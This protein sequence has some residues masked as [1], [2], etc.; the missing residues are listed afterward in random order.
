MRCP[1]DDALAAFV[2]GRLPGPRVRGVAEHVR[3]CDACCEVIEQYASA[4]ELDTP[5][6][7]AGLTDGLAPSQPTIAAGSSP[8]PGQMFARFVLLHLAGRGGMADVYAAYDPV[9]DRK[10]ALKLLHGDR[11]ARERLLHEAR[12]IAAID[13]PHVVRIF[14]L[15]RAHGRD[16]IAMEYVD[17]GTLAQWLASRPEPAAIVHAFV[18]AGRGLCAAHARGIVHRDFKPSNVLVTHVA[19]RLD[20][21][22]V[23]DFGLALPHGESGTRAGTRRYVAPEQATGAPPEPSA[24][25]YSLC[26]A[27]DEA[28]RGCL[29]EQ[30]PTTESV[31]PAASRVRPRVAAAIAR[32]MASDPA[33]R[34]ESMEALLAALSSPRP[35]GRAITVGAAAL[36]V[37]SIASV[38]GAGERCASA[39]ALQL[40]LWSQ[41][42]RTE[43]ARA[44]ADTGLPYAAASWTRTQA[45][46]D[47]AAD[48]WAA[49]AWE[50]CAAADAVAVACNDEQR[51]RIAST[52]AVVRAADASTVIHAD[53][54][55][56]A[57]G[58][59]AC[60]EAAAS[61]PEHDEL[62]AALAAAEAELRA[63]HSE[64]ARS[65]LEQV[66]ARATASEDMGVRRAAVLVLAPLRA[67]FG[68]LDAAAADLSALA[69]DALAARDD[70]VAL[71][72][73]VALARLDG[74]ERSDAIAAQRWDREAT[75]L[76][77]RLGDPLGPRVLL[78]QARGALHLQLGEADRAIAAM[79]RA[80]ALTQ[81]QWGPDDHRT[82][83]V[84][85]N[86]GL[87]HFRAGE[88]DDAQREVQRSLEIRER[89]LGPE[90]PE[91]AAS[92]DLLAAIVRHSAP[93]DALA[94]A[95]RAV[96]IYERSHGPN[97]LSTLNGRVHLGTMLEPSDLDAAREQTRIA[98]AGLER[99]L[100]EHHIYVA[101]ASSNLAQI[102]IQ[103]DDFEA[104]LAASRRAVAAFEATRPED[105]VE[106]VQAILATGRALRLLERTDEARRWLTLGYQRSASAPPARRAVA[107][108]ALA[109]LELDI[110][111]FERAA[112]LSDE[113]TVAW[114]EAYGA[115]HP[116]AVASRSFADKA[117]ASAAAAPQR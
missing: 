49:R 46:I 63:G 17:G 27:L 35:A 102:E 1:D 103:R 99:T 110:G 93:A 104:A 96:A 30:E 43:A 16:Y 58:T 38:A 8:T 37:I 14:D 66:V 32:G 4:F 54:L 13:D 51:A 50:A 91:V 7:S 64:L 80:L 11:E 23:A 15:G 47:H 22:L 111:A 29:P 78:E 61:G 5:R 3:G 67:S 56:D 84:H 116:E 97:H 72:A 33:A 70:R 24:D 115:E 36:V 57:L 101:R 83:A 68:E 98:I 109:E 40:A 6:L 26:V 79:R 87:A 108:D 100:G 12:A 73:F 86:V 34:F 19:G 31:P 53:A 28:L 42:A 76:S 113:S 52:I 77:T 60:A 105:D 21:V 112:I 18:A 85:R 55:V 39:D 41:R 71:D 25:Q 2:E 95:E 20:R 45:A 90:H 74:A 92:L 59:E 9:L 69:F 65:A 48:G 114:T 10:V 44:F 117:R 75:A 106:L 62:V 81:T 107:A 82:A 89:A 88:L 94:H